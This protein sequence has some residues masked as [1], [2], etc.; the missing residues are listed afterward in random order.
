MTPIP[1]GNLVRISW[2]SSDGIGKKQLTAFLSKSA[3]AMNTSI[4]MKAC[5]KSMNLSRYFA[6]TSGERVAEPSMTHKPLMV[7]NP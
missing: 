6:A 5:M 1:T 2:I 7:A 3:T 4:D